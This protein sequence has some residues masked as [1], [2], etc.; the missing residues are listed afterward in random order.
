M[1]AVCSGITMLARAKLYGRVVYS[2]VTYRQ[3]GG[4]CNIVTL[5]SCIAC[6]VETL[7][8]YDSKLDIVHALLICQ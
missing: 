1:V 5:F 8:L 6:C 3:V 4:L 2:G 7:V